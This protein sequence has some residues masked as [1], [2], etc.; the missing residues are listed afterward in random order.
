VDVGARPADIEP[1]TGSVGAPLRRLGEDEDL[2]SRDVEHHQ[3]ISGLGSIDGGRR[4]G[5][6]SQYPEGADSLT[7]EHIGD[8]RR[9]PTRLGKSV[10][11]RGQTR[12]RCPVQG[13]TKL[14]G[15][16]DGSIDA[17]AEAALFSR[18]AQRCDAEIGDGAPAGAPVRINRPGL[19]G[20]RGP[21]GSTQR[22]AELTKVV[23][24]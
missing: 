14:G 4:A 24:G 6:G 12:E 20:F 7:A 10:G 16:G 22:F 8:E 18:H 9:I 17:Q 2:V 21:E 3:G 23:V 15:R 13:G 19:V 1:V 5:R 11:A